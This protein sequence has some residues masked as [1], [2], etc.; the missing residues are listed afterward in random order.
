MLD[1]QNLF[2]VFIDFLNTV[3]RGFK[4]NSL[5]VA[6]RSDILLTKI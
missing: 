1:P 2:T 4:N 6:L 3:R 5:S